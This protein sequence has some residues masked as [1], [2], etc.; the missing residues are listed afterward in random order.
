MQFSALLYA[1]DISYF[2]K[3]FEP[4]NW[5]AGK[6]QPFPCLVKVRI[7]FFLDMNVLNLSRLGGQI[8]PPPTNSFI[9]Y[10]SALQTLRFLDFL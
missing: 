6:K 2:V 8:F 3:F 5:L 1:Y 9:P 10:N 4:E 7:W